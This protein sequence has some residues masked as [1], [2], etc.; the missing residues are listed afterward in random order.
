MAATESQKPVKVKESF[1][2]LGVLL[3]LSGLFLLAMLGRE[4]FRQYQSERKLQPLIAKAKAQDIPL[5][6]E[7]V[8][9]DPPAG[10]PNAAPEFEKAFAMRKALSE[11][12]SKALSYY[13]TPK[14][15]SGIEEALISAEPMLRQAERAVAI[16][17][18]HFTHDAN[19]GPAMLMKE[20]AYMKALA[21]NFAARSRLRARSGLDEAALKDLQTIRKLEQCMTMPGVITMMVRGSCEKMMAD[22][23]EENI[24]NCA[25]DQV[26][27]SKYRDLAQ[28]APKIDLIKALRG[29]A[30]EEI[31]V[32]KT[33]EQWEKMLNTGLGESEYVRGEVPPTWRSKVALSAVLASWTRLFEQLQPVIDD[34]TRAGAVLDAFDKRH[35]AECPMLEAFF[36]FEDASYAGAHEVAMK[37]ED[38]WLKVEALLAK[39]SATPSARSQRVP[40]H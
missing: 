19:E 10:T 28:K 11:T 17:S 39:Y 34:R 2:P 37:Y 36:K 32:A 5:V 27:L 1:W 9:P 12:D 8:Y 29:A 15:T 40:S 31:V 13:G 16:G 18:C 22:V 24:Q 6:A 25:A 20:L 38:T 30:W 4:P 23:A 21:K 14:Y 35:Q 7:D 26:M 3:A 33:I